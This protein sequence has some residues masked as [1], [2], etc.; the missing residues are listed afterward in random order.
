MY[1]QQSPATIDIT[2]DCYQMSLQVLL[3]GASGI[4]SQ[5]IFDQVITSIIYDSR[6]GLPGAVFFALPGIHVNGVDFISDAISRGV[7]A[8]IHQDPF[9]ASLSCE[10][11]SC[12]QVRDIRHS[13][14]E[15]SARFYRNPSSSISVIGITGT[16]GK[17]STS[18]FLHH[19]LNEQGIHCGLS[20]TVSQDLGL[21]KTD[22]PYRQSTP[23]APVI[24]HML[25]AARDRGCSHFV[26]ECTSHALSYE[27]KRLAH[28]QF[29]G[30]VFTGISS[31][32]LEFHKTWDAY[33]DAKLNL[34]RSLS[35]TT[36]VAILP[37]DTPID[38]RLRDASP[39]NLLIVKETPDHELSPAT[40]HYHITE[41]TP[42]GILCDVTWSDCDSS[43]VCIPL[44]LPIFV[45]DAM[46]AM[47]AAMSLGNTG[48]R[49]TLKSLSHLRSVSGRLEI[50]KDS[51]NRTLIIDFAH[52]QDAF[53]KVFTESRRK[54]PHSRFIAVFGSA[55][56]RDVNK[57][58][59]LGCVASQ[60]CAIIIL[61][62]EDSRSESQETITSH[63]L[64]GYD[65]HSSACVLI[66]HDRARAIHLAKSL[67]VS[68]DVIFFLGKGHEKSIQRCDT[69]I[70]WSERDAVIKTFTLSLREVQV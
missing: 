9:P 27:T 39:P 26:L 55:G 18:E 2:M 13:L 57:R 3:Q 63:I 28:V 52:T 47:A 53:S 59:G 21:G 16:D 37:D 32:H 38:A 48:F 5:R 31:E 58:T 8:I 51:A 69:T 42:T 4:V 60:H 54:Y 43:S 67:S 61:T 65:P 66:E 23:E 44:P 49:D 14:S 30:A 15:L 24:H 12:V 29:S 62:E 45:R 70:P 41:D 19:I 11:I 68:G 22:S 25:A 36:G 40:L 7:S 33:V 46:L 10:G 6:K 34:F 20:T 35:P 64:E 1:I 56:E 17:T 50:F